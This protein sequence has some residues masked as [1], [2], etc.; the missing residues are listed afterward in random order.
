MLVY[1]SIRE[2]YIERGF[3]QIT[4]LMMTVENT[5]GICTKDIIGLIYKKHSRKMIA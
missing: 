5:A 3:I 2:Q 4:I 1:N